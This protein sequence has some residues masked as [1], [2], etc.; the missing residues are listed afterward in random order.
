MIILRANNIAGRV[1]HCGEIVGASYDCSLWLFRE[2][3]LSAAL[4][5]FM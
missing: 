3:Q 4:R 2:K 5:D 1:T